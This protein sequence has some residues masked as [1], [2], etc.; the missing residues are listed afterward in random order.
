MPNRCFRISKLVSIASS[1]RARLACG[2]CMCGLGTAS[3]VSGAATISMVQSSYVLAG[4]GPHTYLKTAV[5]A[6]LRGELIP[7]PHE[8]A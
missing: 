7:L 8:V 3:F 1:A 4:F 6:A 5:G 2:G